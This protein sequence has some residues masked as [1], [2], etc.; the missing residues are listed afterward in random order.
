[1]RLCE[2]PRASSAR[3]PRRRRVART[4]SRGARMRAG[5][6]A[7]GL[8]PR[9]AWEAL[10]EQS[11]LHLPF[12]RVTH[13]LLGLARTLFRPIAFA[14]RMGPNRNRANVTTHI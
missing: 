12:Y 2:G 14:S 10:A 1:M 11:F 4:N 8:G 6:W 5:G 13:P 3:G 9:G 7:W